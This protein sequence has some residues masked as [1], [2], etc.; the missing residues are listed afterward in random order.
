MRERGEGERGGKEG[1][2]LGG[3]RET[4]WSPSLSLFSEIFFS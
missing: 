4:S 3:G 2:K 1:E